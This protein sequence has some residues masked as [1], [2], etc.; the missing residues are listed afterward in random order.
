MLQNKKL[1]RE[2]FEL[3]DPNAMFSDSRC[4]ISGKLLD[5]LPSSP[6][7]QP[8]FL[9][10]AAKKQETCGTFVI[11]Y[12]ACSSVAVGLMFVYWSKSRKQRPK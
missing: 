1:G 4:G 12:R 7:K 2:F 11:Q 10:I 6:E 5:G 9:P 8:A 3:L